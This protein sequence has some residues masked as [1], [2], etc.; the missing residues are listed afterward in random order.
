MKLM[1]RWEQLSDEEQQQ[2]IVEISTFLTDPDYNE[3]PLRDAVV[4]KSSNWLRRMVAGCL[5]HVL[6]HAAIQ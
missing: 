2:R 3:T 1:P 6:R 4:V 5:S